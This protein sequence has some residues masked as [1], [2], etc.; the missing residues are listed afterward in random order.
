MIFTQNLAEFQLLFVAFNPRFVSWTAD[1]KIVIS[2]FVLLTD[3]CDPL[4]ILFSE[5]PASGL[6]SHDMR[7]QLSFILSEC[8]S[9]NPNSFAGFG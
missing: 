8:H 1:A 7:E 5:N 6:I 2:L 3:L 4:D 9:A